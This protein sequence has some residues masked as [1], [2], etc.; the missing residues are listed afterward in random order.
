M[1]QTSHRVEIKVEAPHDKPNNH[2]RSSVFTISL[3]SPL[4]VAQ[5]QASVNKLL[6]DLTTAALPKGEG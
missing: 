2:Y 4:P 3:E 1:S 6:T 5:I